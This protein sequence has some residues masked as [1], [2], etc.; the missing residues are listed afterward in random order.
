[1]QR[2]ISLEQ[3]VNNDPIDKETEDLAKILDEK[4]KEQNELIEQRR[5]NQTES[6][7]TDAVKEMEDRDR[8]K[9]NIVLHNIAESSAAEPNARKSDDVKFVEQLF[10][11]HLK[12]DV[13]PKL[14]K[15]QQPMIFRLGKKN[16]GKS[17]SMKIV[18][19]PDD[20]AKVLKKAKTLALATDEKIKKI[21]IKPD[22]TPM[23]REE[24]QKLV[25]EKNEKNKEALT[26]NEPADWIIQRWKVVRR[27]R[28]QVPK[29]NAATS[30]DS[31]NEE[32]ADATNEV[33]DQDQTKKE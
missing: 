10:K 18:L 32:Y 14:D 17:R 6:S 24:E 9:N 4:I 23:Q 12:I 27:P 13:K 19:Q 1:M 7:L 22:L 26:K 3:K 29:A 33:K 8:R 25:K 28:N 20:V 30:T 5:N 11:E 21:V 15:S 2:V 31:L 16:D